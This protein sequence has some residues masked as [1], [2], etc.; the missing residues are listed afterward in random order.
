MEKFTQKDLAYITDI[1]EWNENALKLANDFLEREKNAE[2][3]D[4]EVISLLEEVVGMH[5]ENLNRCI[6]ILNG[7]DYTSCH[8]EDMEGYSEDEDEEKE[9]EDDE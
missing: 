3:A 2:N 5:Y 9:E 1:F 8:C 4:T 6:C 7:Q